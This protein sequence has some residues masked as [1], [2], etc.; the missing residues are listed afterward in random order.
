M[1]RFIL[2]GLFT[3]VHAVAPAAA[4][5]VVDGAS[6]HPDH[7]VPEVVR[8]TFLPHFYLRFK[9]KVRSQQTAPSFSILFIRIW[10]R[11]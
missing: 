4:A 5:P 11:F 8:T 9:E 1:L 3:D 7:Y 10:G 2:P 6:E